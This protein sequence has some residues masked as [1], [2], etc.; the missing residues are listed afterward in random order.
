MAM[1]M[2]KCYEDDE[3]FWR[4]MAVMVVLGVNE[5]NLP[6]NCILRQGQIVNFMYI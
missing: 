3:M 5:L 4:W 2:M 6:W 1:E